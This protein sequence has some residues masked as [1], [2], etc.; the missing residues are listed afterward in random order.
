MFST[1]LPQFLTVAILHAGF[2]MLPGSDFAL[3]VRMTARRGPGAAM[4]VVWG[5]A[6]GSLL[7]TCAAI[8]GL[9][10]LVTSF[11]NSMNIIRFIGAGWLLWQAFLAFSVM[12]KREL[13]KHNH[14]T[15]ATHLSPFA[16]G[17]INHAVNGEALLFY[18][19]VI[20]QYSTR[21][22][23]MPLEFVSALEMATMIALW[24]SI[25][26]LIIQKLPHRTHVLT[27]PITRT[28]V[29]GLFLVAAGGLILGIS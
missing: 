19:A 11:P 22:I 21:S 1:F 2:I 12:P 5:L 29:G 23:P 8:V 4:Q 7:I 15:D 18:G 28:I 14:K 3:I 9:N 13:K 20:T 27:H 26:V 17:V 25:A 10:T 24:F 6:V 16:T